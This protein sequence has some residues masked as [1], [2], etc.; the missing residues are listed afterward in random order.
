M[1]LLEHYIQPGYKVKKIP[2][3]EVP[4]NYDR[5]CYQGFVTFDGKVDCYGNIQQVHEIFSVEEWNEI[6]KQGYY[7][8]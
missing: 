8:G 1:N 4:F 5:S 3:E 7:M 6:R 2:P